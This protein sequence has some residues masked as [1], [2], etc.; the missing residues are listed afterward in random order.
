MVSLFEPNT[1]K[2]RSTSR[3]LILE[4]KRDGKVLATSG[5]ASKQIF[6][7]R[8]RLYLTMDEQTC[9]WSFH[10]DAGVVPPALNQ[11]FTSFKDAFYFAKN[12]FD[13]RGIDIVEVI[14]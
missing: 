6:T 1:E 8:N 11:S 4:A 14:D 9:L 7:G 10:Y 5:K 13:K 3:Q 2:M 12:Y